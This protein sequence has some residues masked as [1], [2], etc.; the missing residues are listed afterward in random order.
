MNGINDE[1][2]VLSAC[3]ANRV[4]PSTTRRAVLHERVLLPDFQDS[5][6]PNFR[7]PTTRFSEKV[8]RAG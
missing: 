3:S 6:Y 8:P 1:T 2:E 4:S 7:S 5:Y